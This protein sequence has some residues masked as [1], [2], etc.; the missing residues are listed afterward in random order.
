MGLSITLLLGGAI[1]ALGM[2]SMRSDVE[3]RPTDVVSQSLVV[4]DELANRL[5][6]LVALPLTLTSP[7]ALALS[8]RRGRTRGLDRIGGGAKIVRGDVGDGR[9]LA[10]GIRGMPRRPSQVSGRAHRMSGCRARLGHRDLATRPGAGQLDRLTRSRILRSNRL[11][12]VKDV[13]CARRR[14]QGEEV[15]IRVGE[16]PTPADRHETWVAYFR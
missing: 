13:L 15:V 14:P 16:C 11:E 9:S 8:W 3:H 5:R 4:E 2:R 10:S 1:S 7:C 6:E 12:E